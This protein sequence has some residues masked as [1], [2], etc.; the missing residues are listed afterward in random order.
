MCRKF[1]FSDPRVLYAAELCSDEVNFYARYLLD[2]A[3]GDVQDTGVAASLDQAV[4]DGND[5]GALLTPAYTFL[6][7]VAKRS[8]NYDFAQHALLVHGKLSM[9]S[10]CSTPCAAEGIAVHAHLTEN[11]TGTMC[12]APKLQPLVKCN[13]DSQI[14]MYCMQE[15]ADCNKVRP[16]CSSSQ[17]APLVFSSLHEIPTILGPVRAGQGAAGHTP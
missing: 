12:D 5:T 4:R 7:T 16:R 8:D 3:N 9:A 17:M 11:E 2:A 15:T 1:G 13:L 14:R 10:V 6:E